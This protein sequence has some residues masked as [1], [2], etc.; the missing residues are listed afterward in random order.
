MHYIYL[1]Y[2]LITITNL[3]L[4]TNISGMAAIPSQLMRTQDI[5]F[6]YW[7]IFKYQVHRKRNTALQCVNLVRSS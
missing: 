3:I 6:E 1:T 7:S 2:N 5:R 4:H